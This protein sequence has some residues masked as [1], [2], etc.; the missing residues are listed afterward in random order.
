MIRLDKALSTLTDLNP[1]AA[2]QL[3]SDVSDPSL[4]GRTASE[5]V[6]DQR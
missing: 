2:Q 5:N 3:L 4:Y 6:S 1:H